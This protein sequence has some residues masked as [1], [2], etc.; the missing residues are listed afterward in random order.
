MEEA[1]SL[2]DILVHKDDPTHA[3]VGKGVEG[4][5]WS[6]KGAVRPKDDK[7]VI[8]ELRIVNYQLR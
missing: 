4:S 8:E 7:T 6:N 5:S 2:L 3:N 1:D